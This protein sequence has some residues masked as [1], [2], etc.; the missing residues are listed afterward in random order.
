MYSNLKVL[1]VDDDITMANSVSAILQ[2]EDYDLQ[3]INDPKKAFPEINKD[4]YDLVI[5]DVMM[6]GMTGFELLEAVDRDKIDTFFIIMTGD[7][8]MESA[9][10]AI[11][12]GANDYIKKPFDPDELIIR[13]KNL[14]KQIRLNQRNHQIEKEKRTLEIELRQSQKME[15]I[16]TLTGGI[17][18]DFNNILGIILGNSE[19]ALQDLDEFEPVRQNLEKVFEA[20]NRAK[21]MINQLLSFSRKKDSEQKP[22]GLN[23]IIIDSL[24]LLRASIPTN[25]AIHHDISDT[26]H[27]VLGDTTQIHQIMIN[28]CT[29]AAH[30]MQDSGGVLSVRLNSMEIG[31]K[32]IFEG[33]LLPEGEFVQLIIS[34]TG[35]GIPTAVK[36]RIFDPY[37]TTKKP[38][39]GTGMGLAVVH[40]IVKRHGG[41]IHV[42]SE[43]D[44]GT[45]FHIFLP[46]VDSQESVV[47]PLAETELPRGKEKILL[48]DDEEMI[49]DIMTQML[50]QLGYQVSE[51][52]QSQAALETF[53][54]SPDKFDL[55]I[56]DMTMPSL[57]GDILAKEI[58]MIRGDIPVILC[59]GF[60]EKL[61]GPNSFDS[62][63][64]AVIMKPVGMIELAETIRRE[65]D[66]NHPERRREERYHPQKGAFI[67]S[68]INPDKQGEIIDISRSGLAFQYA[69]NGD[70]SD[71]FDHLSIKTVDHSFT[72]NDISYETVSEAAS[73]DFSKRMPGV[74]KRIGGK[75]GGLTPQQGEQLTYFLENYT[76]AMR[77]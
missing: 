18:H 22:I 12:L 5:L 73:E 11:R 25:I 59:S 42:F 76:T 62:A 27:T 66:R 32:P 23:A 56:T 10:E 1:I 37:F 26:T 69:R 47:E 74:L 67:I 49:V 24:K 50:E 21:E 46:L 65:I 9:V 39:K 8:S 15:A 20:G 61:K 40:G 72:L 31:D 71:Q 45:K 17:A 28:L 36:D 55:V 30:A 77:N 43:M 75:F 44:T 68:K 2:C 64:Q 6:P 3:I 51:H 48:V 52:T 13:V 57:T 4:R 41:E 35:Y 19:L 54:S 7:A 60:N 16:G 70:R 29:N 63:I 53:R 38:D 34:D 58:K 33:S 14:V